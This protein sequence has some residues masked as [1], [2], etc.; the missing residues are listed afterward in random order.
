M[1]ARTCNVSHIAAAQCAHHQQPILVIRAHLQD[2]STPERLELL[3]LFSHCVWSRTSPA[4]VC[5]A[6]VIRIA[7]S[8]CILVM[9]LT[10]PP[11]RQ[12]P[13]WLAL[14]RLEPGWRRI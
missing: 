1:L 10:S 3:R 4:V 12:F 5:M 13:I 9:R 11:S 6:P 14:D 8:R 7:A 2:L